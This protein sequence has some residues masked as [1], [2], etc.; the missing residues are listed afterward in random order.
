MYVPHPVDDDAVLGVTRR[1][2]DRGPRPIL[3]QAVAGDTGHG[4]HAVWMVQGIANGQV[5][6][7]GMTEYGPGCD[8][9]CRSDCFEVGDRL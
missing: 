3:V 4:T 2:V 5:R 1:F 8:T 7:E 6:P 9:H